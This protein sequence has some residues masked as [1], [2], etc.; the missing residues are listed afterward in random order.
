MQLNV[1]LSENN[2]KYSVK[3]STITYKCSTLINDIE[4]N[5]MSKIKLHRVN[6]ARAG[7]ENFNNMFYWS[8]LYKKVYFKFRSKKYI[9]GAL[10]HIV[11]IID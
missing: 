6:S 8:I 2:V 7:D 9:S 11:Y 4:S 3:Y 10:M 5:G 1:C